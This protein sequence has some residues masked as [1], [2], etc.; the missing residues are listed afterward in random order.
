MAVAVAEVAA[1]VVILLLI[2]SFP[3]E[4]SQSDEPTMFK[5]ALTW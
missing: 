2:K 3:T 1:M 4:K 5:M